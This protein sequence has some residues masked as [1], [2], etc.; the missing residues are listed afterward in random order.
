MHYKK[1]HTF[2]TSVDDK[3]KLKEAIDSMYT[4]G[5]RLGLNLNKTNIKSSILAIA[6]ECMTIKLVIIYKKKNFELLNYWSSTELYN[7][8]NYSEKGHNIFI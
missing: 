4:I 6:T 1:L 5:H 3:L 2:V 7:H 8:L